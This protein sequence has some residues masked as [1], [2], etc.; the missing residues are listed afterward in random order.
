MSHLLIF[1][2]SLI[3]YCQCA[4]IPNDGN[5]FYINAMQGSNEVGIN[6]FEVEIGKKL[7]GQPQ[8]ITEMAMSTLDATIAVISTTCPSSC[9]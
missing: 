3:T 5:Y 6:E 4:P 8:I 2:G 1:L 9:G 7:N